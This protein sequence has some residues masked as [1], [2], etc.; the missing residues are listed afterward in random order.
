VSSTATLTYSA[1]AV[2]PTTVANLAAAM[3][4]V[5]LDFGEIE[6]ATGCTFGSDTTTEVGQVVTR[7]IVFDINNA[8]FLGN[9][10]NGTDQAS[11]FRNLYTLVL[12]ESLA[13]FITAGAVVIA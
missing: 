2:G 10:P 13:C 6:T 4:A 5:D 11:P 3:A 9:F 12:S 7:T 8:T 1:T